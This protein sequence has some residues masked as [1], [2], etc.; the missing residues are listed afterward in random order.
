MVRSGATPM[1]EWR[2]STLTKLVQALGEPEFPHLLLETLNERTRISHFTIIAFDHELT[3]HVVAAESIGRPLAK[4]AQRIYEKGL[5]FRH[6]PNVQIISSH[7]EPVSRPLLF[8][9]K[10]PEIENEA[11]RGQIFEQFGLIERISMIEYFA[12]QWNAISFYR[13]RETG[14]FSARDVKQF[15]EAAELVVA[16]VAKHFALM[17][18]PPWRRD[19]RP[20]VEQLERIVYGLDPALTARQ[21]QV[22]ARALVGLTNTAIGHD[23]GIQAPTV[24][25][26]R[27]RAYAVLKISSLNE[28]FALCLARSVPQ[29]HAELRPEPRA[30]KRSA[31]H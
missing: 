23:L 11:Y 13:D 22:C 24:A 5:H 26:L 9:L 10:V 4:A 30:R 14:P 15:E 6:D 2:S 28:L 21:V 31:S 19:T 29:A 7:A 12:G 17:P 20:P 1:R 25:T 18:P 27:K 16:L 8:H 3:G